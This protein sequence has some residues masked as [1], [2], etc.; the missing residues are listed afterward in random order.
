[1]ASAQSHFLSP[2]FVF[3]VYF[4]LPVYFRTKQDSMEGRNNNEKKVCPKV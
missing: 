2:F 4:V 1:M 3:P